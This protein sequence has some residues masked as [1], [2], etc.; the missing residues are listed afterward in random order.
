[1]LTHV[2]PVS[3]PS[4]IKV[5]ITQELIDYAPRGSAFGCAL[6]RATLI[7]TG[8]EFSCVTEDKIVWGNH[9]RHWRWTM[10]PEVL[11]ARRRLDQHLPV[12]PF[13]FEMHAMVKA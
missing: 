1:M 4:P 6:A 5:F 13:T 8:E 10:T 9:E 3:H 2:P 11:A 12:S 7:A